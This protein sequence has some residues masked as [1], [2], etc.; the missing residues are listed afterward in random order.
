M[1]RRAQRRR[2]KS[3]QVADVLS[4]G[5]LLELARAARQRAYA[6]YSRFEVGAALLTQ[7]GRTFTGCNVENAS[8][9][10]SMC[11]ERNAVFAA[12]S[13]GVRTFVAIA[14]AGAPGAACLPCGACRQVLAEFNPALAVTYSDAA[15]ATTRSLSELL[16]APFLPE[17]LKAPS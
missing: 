11:A 17:N 14:I 12:V 13:A 16:P 1:E 9:G 7:D 2:F 5:E 3:N 15:S 4:S 6:P 10:L 8:Y